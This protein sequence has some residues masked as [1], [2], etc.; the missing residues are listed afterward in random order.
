MWN[1]GLC[2]N[3]SGNR[4]PEWISLA[5]PLPACSLESLHGH[6]GDVMPAWRACIYLKQVPCYMSLWGSCQESSPQPSVH[7]AHTQGGQGGKELESCWSHLLPLGR[8]L[9]IAVFSVFSDL[10]KEI[11]PLQCVFISA[12]FSWKRLPSS[13]ELWQCPEMVLVITAVERGWLWAGISSG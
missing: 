3:E 11:G 2:E 12:L 9:W 13:G 5:L 6:Q 7:V 4:G 10:Q 1:M 8:W